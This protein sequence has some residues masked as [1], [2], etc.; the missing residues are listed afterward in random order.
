MSLDPAHLPEYAARTTL[1]MFAALALSL[2]FTLTYATWAAK[3]ERAGKLLVPILDI[4]QS[5]PILGFISV[6]VVFFMSLAPGPGARR[7]IRGDLRHLHQ[8]GLEYGVQFL[9]ILAHGSHRTHRGRRI[10]PPLALD[11]VLAARGSLRHAGAGLEHDDV[12]VRRLVLRGRLRVDQRGTHHRGAARGR[13]RTSRSPS[14]RRISPPSAG[15]SPR[16]CS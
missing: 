14:S 4:L 11:A 7:G 16:C 10:V 15:R 12:D 9:S 6:T 1:R 3:S 8:P 13:V 2:V 5:V